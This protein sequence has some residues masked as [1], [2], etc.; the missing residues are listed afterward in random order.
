MSY[1]WDPLSHGP[2]PLNAKQ[3]LP[4]SKTPYKIQVTWL[5]H[6]IESPQLLLSDSHH[7]VLLSLADPDQEP[8]PWE[9]A[10]GGAELDGPS[11]GPWTEPFSARDEA[12]SLG[13]ARPI[14]IADDISKL[15]DTFSFRYT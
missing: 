8:S 11:S 2:T 13:S 3:Y 4:T 5:N 6:E 1:V 14:V 7:Y 10:A 12:E 15:D 9:A